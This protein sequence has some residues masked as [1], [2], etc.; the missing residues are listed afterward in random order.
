MKIYRDA[1]G[2][3][4]TTPIRIYYGGDRN[5]LA[6]AKPKG[7][8]QLVNDLRAEILHYTLR[9]AGYTTLIVGIGTV[10]RYVILD[11]AL[12]QAEQ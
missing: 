4:M 10:C 12:P 3:L 5:F 1:G 6:A 8:L 11:Y 2:V 9:Q 7:A